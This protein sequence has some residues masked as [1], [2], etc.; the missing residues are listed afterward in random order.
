MIKGSQF[1]Q[2]KQEKDQYVKL[3]RKNWIHNGYEY[4]LGLNVDPNFEPKGK[5]GFYF[6]KM[7]DCSNWIHYGNK[8][9]FWVCDVEIPD[10]ADVNVEED[11]IRTNQFILSHARELA[12]DAK[13]AE[14]LYDQRLKDLGNRGTELDAMVNILPDFPKMYE[15]WKL[16]ELIGK[17]PA[18]ISHIMLQNMLTE[19]V[20]KAVIGAIEKDNKNLV[21][22]MRR[23]MVGQ[24]ASGVARLVREDERVISFLTHEHMVEE[25]CMEM[26]IKMKPINAKMRMTPYHLVALVKAIEEGTF[27]PT[28]DVLDKMYNVARMY[29]DYRFGVKKED[30]VATIL[31]L[32]NLALRGKN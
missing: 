32:H 19:D 23:H 15:S 11:Q 28:A 13:E 12:I 25:V 10:D 31:R 21:F 1:N 29:R 24:I 26:M 3:L 8:S 6:C 14:R 17:D 30:V 9:M 20:E 5:K 2:Q 4:T 18:T 27:R 22:V 16:I 7:S